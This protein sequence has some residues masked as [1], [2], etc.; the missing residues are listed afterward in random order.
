MLEAIVV[1]V[2]VVV[3]D[4]VGGG[5]AVCDVDFALLLLHR[6]LHDG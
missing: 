3:V 5:A 1:V 2:V 6:Y 4:D